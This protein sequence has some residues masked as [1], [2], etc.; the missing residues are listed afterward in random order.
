M[1]SEMEFD[2]VTK[3]T[4]EL[5]TLIDLLI[6]NWVDLKI[7]NVPFNTVANAIANATTNAACK[8]LAWAKK[9]GGVLTDSQCLAVGCWSF[10]ETLKG[11][12]DIQGAVHASVT[13]A[14][15]EKIVEIDRA[16]ETA[17]ARMNN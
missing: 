12:L 2:D 11:H 15:I 7:D 16:Y 4:D 13:D 9:Q 5:Y 14:M 17:I 8:G 3:L 1:K 6:H 10:R